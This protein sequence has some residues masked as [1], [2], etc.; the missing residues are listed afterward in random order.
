MDGCDC[1]DNY[2]DRYTGKNEENM[3]DSINERPVDDISLEFFYK[4]H[5]I[6]L[7]SVSIIAL[8]YT[9]FTRNDE[10]S[11]ENNIWAGIGCV[12]F[13][14]LVISILAFPNGP[15][16]RPHPAVW[17]VVF[18]LS[19]LYL[20][21][22]LFILFQN[23]QTVKSIMY[24][25]YPDLKGFRIATEKEYAVNCSDITLERI[26]SHMDVF[27]VGHF[28]GWTM[29]AMLVR[30]YGIC[31]TISVTWEIT[32]VAFAHLLPNF[33]ECWWDALVLD[34]LLCNGLGIWFGMCICNF[35]EM[36]T[37]KWEG[38]KNIQSTSGKIR[39]AVLQFT[40]ANWTNMRWLDPSCTYVRFFAVT[41]LVIFWQI[42]ELNTFFLKHIFEVPPGHPLSIGRLGLIGLIVAPTLRQ[43][44]VYVTD[45]HCKRVGTQCW[46]FGAIMFTEAIIC[47]KFGLNLFARTHIHKIVYWVVTQFVLSIICVSVCV[48]WAKKHEK[49]LFYQ[50]I[51]NMVVAKRIRRHLRSRSLENIKFWRS[52]DLFS[53]VFNRQSSKTN[54]KE[55]KIHDD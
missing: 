11:I 45:A 28:L 2:S 13:F 3:F 19:V 46:V 31:W 55:N 22:L 1:D 43:Y 7:L 54:E 44:Y 52:E 15:F 37:Y 8:L 39:R 29:K 26:W 12:V 34:V 50:N 21:T 36:R 14:F 18:G 48:L 53:S 30:H 24:W 4:P 42:T 41:E 5:T 20:M 10:I 16:T 40:P 49:I 17:R 25:F 23:Y 51:Q 35:F 32:E 6:T 47:V 27:A 33:A 9:A 38:I